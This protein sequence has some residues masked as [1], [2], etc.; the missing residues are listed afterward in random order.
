MSSIKFFIA[1]ILLAILSS[2]SFAQD[3]AKD[4]ET[5]KATIQSAYVDGLQN[6]GDVDKIDKGF[7]PDFNLLGIGKNNQMW[8]L[9]ITKWK[10]KVV[11][12]VE[13]GEMPKKGDDRVTIK[14]LNVDVTGTAAVAK[15]EFYIGPKL[16]YIDYISLYKFDKEWKIV[17]KIFYKL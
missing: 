5:I 4:I 8:K 13:K 9:S 1:I 3:N 15:I 6:D 10:E 14:F 17:N 16:T 2:Y 12:K 7:H 11:Q